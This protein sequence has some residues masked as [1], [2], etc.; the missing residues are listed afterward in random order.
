MQADRQQQRDLNRD[1]RRTTDK[2]RFSSREIR[3]EIQQ[4]RGPYRGRRRADLTD[5]NKQ[6]TTAG[7]RFR[8]TTSDLDSGRHTTD[9]RQ[10]QA[11]RTSQAISDAERGKTRRMQSHMKPT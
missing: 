9:S 4:Q 5:N 10:M 1:R 2:Y 6:Q 8:Q 3:T 7:S 11:D